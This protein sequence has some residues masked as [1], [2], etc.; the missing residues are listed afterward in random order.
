M[1]SKKLIRLVSLLFLTSPFLVSCNKDKVPDFDLKKY[2]ID[3]DEIEFYELNG[4]YYQ[5][6]YKEKQANHAQTI[7]D[8]ELLGGHLMTCETEE[9]FMLLKYTNSWLSKS[10]PVGMVKLPG[11]NE[12]QWVTGEKVEPTYRALKKAV[13]N[14]TDTCPDNEFRYYSTAC[15]TRLLFPKNDIYESTLS[16]DFRTVTH[17]MLEWDS[18]DDIRGPRKYNLFTPVD[19]STEDEFINRMSIKYPGGISLKNDITFT[20]KVYFETATSIQ[21][22]N[23]T[24][25]FLKGA[26]GGNDSF[27]FNKVE[28][29]ITF[30]DLII[31]HEVEG[32]AKNYMGGFIN[33]LGGALKNVTFKGKVIATNV[34]ESYRTA[35]LVLL[36]KKTSSIVDCV[37]EADL[38]GYHD[39][40]GIFA[41]SEGGAEIKGCIN[42]GNITGKNSLGGIG[43]KIVTTLSSSIANCKNEG[44][45]TGN[46]EVGGIVGRI[47]L[48]HKSTNVMDKFVDQIDLINCDNKGAIVGTKQVGGC[49]GSVHGESNSF[50]DV[51]TSHC[52]IDLVFCTNHGTINGEDAIQDA[53][54]YIG[55]VVGSFYADGSSSYLQSC[56]VDGVYTNPIGGYEKG[57]VVF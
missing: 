53:K 25:K 45:I 47:T 36:A 20:K 30:K 13:K 17:Y 26:S 21:G 1:K 16:F 57:S 51:G 40:G 31:E 9:E 24:L 7:L 49:F 54:N 41:A 48:E 22:N 43:G 56:A 28:N 42:K 34:S 39:I 19:V 12:L 23:H 55:N 44:N 46:I 10:L 8:G 27:I 32:S 15:K 38:A 18:F 4:H 3:G 52:N 29:G 35:G 50:M 14:F 6:I 5:L 33:E 37:N 2:K 11:S